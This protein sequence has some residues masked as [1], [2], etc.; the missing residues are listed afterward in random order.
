MQ[1]TLVNI[2]I[3]MLGKNSKKTE[4]EYYMTALQL[5]HQVYS[6]QK[7]H[8]DDE[9][10]AI[11]KWACVSLGIEYKKP[12]KIPAPALTCWSTVLECAEYLLQHWDILLKISQ[13]V[14]N[15]RLTS[16]AINQIAS[17]NQALLR[18]YISKCEVQLIHMCST[19][20]FNDHFK[21]L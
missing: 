14:I 12:L 10:H 5:L 2:I 19:Y 11:W 13:G 18:T 17:A 1:L 3:T 9:W 4:M 6:M 15:L 8:E 20:F 16:K 7:Y 21:W